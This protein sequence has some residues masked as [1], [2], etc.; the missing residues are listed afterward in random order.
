MRE[1][2]YSSTILDIS[3][4]WRWVIILTLR[5]LYSRGITA[6][7]YCIGGWCA[8]QSFWTLCGTETSCPYRKSN[9]GPRVR[10]PL[11]YQLS[12][13][14]SMQSWILK[15]HIYLSEHDKLYHCRGIII[16]KTVM[17]D[18]TY[19]TQPGNHTN[20]TYITVPGQYNVG[21]KKTNKHIP[22]SELIFETCG[23]SI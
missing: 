12:Y 1:W 10:N 2:R 23:T 18:G 11:L 8:P 7:T 9:P 5:P 6:G 21:E 15:I 4:R 16:D 13:P 19:V 17:C 14:S 20:I 22:N 3:T